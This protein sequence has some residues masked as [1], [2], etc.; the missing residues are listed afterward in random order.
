MSCA[1]AIHQ[2][3]ALKL[4]STSENLCKGVQDF[5]ECYHN[6][7]VSFPPPDIVTCNFP[8]GLAVPEISRK[9]EALIHNFSNEL[10]NGYEMNAGE[11]C[12]VD[13]SEIEHSYEH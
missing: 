7:V 6:A 10:I 1:K 12:N 8:P 3:C 13:E 11:M 4:V 5:V 9:F 2:K